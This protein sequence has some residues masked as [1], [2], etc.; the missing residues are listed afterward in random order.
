MSSESP[1]SPAPAR[2]TDRKREAIVQ[3]AIDEFRQHG[4]AGTSMD[5]LAAVAG[6]SKRT[7]YN[8]FPSKDELF[9]EIL[10]QLFEHSQAVTGV[11]Y[12][13]TRPLRDQLREL[14][15]QKM[16]LLNDA[17]FISL[18]R[19]GIAEVMHAP[20]RALAIVGR[21]AEKEE[22]LV[23][24]LRAAQADGRLRAV[25]PAYAA[26][27]LQGMV[28]AFAFWPQLTLGQPPLSA[29]EQTRVLDDCVD[30]FL[31][32]HDTGPSANSWKP[33]PYL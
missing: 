23:T 29:A 18:A 12:S 11:A 28:K 17:T 1:S 3:A 25:D 30:M 19:V 32:F 21:M 13:H 16:A 22:A 14:M 27:Q 26:Q 7:V 8:H 31:G 10:H 20:E 4:F 5:R 24:W 33:A 2:L 6:V 15:A 9:A